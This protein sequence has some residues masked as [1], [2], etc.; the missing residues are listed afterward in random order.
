VWSAVRHA[1]EIARSGG[2]PSLIEALT[3]RYG[4]HSYL[5]N[6]L[7]YRTDDEVDVW[8]RNDPIANLG[9]QLV[10]D[11]L[12]TPDQL[13]AVRQSVDDEIERSLEF[14]R[15]SADPKLDSLWP[16]MYTDPSGF[17]A[18]RHNQAWFAKLEPAR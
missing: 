1:A 9:R 5:M 15:G 18:R 10:D 17:A 4:D 8:R 3:Y 16:H 14:A 13:A 7:K 11:Q 2:G 12:V 6:R